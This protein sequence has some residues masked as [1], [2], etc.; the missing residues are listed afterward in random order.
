V[1]GGDDEQLIVLPQQG[2]PAPAPPGRLGDGLRAARAHVEDG[3]ELI[4]HW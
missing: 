2:R 3:L 4:T 1:V